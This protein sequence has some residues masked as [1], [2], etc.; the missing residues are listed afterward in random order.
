MKVLVK[1]EVKVI[2]KVI[3][4]SERGVIEAR[5]DKNNKAGISPPCEI[6]NYL[7]NRLFEQPVIWLFS[8]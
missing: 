5:Y 6:M 8:E 3:V 7:G 4:T 2:T 1:V